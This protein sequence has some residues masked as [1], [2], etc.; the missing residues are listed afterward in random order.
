MNGTMSG[1]PKEANVDMEFLR[2]QPKYSSDHLRLS[3]WLGVR[4]VD[5][6]DDQGTGVILFIPGVSVASILS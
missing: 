2:R 1:V 6:Q 3:D 5:V 4:V